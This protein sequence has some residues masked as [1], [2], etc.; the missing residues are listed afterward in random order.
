MSAEL[1]STGLTEK[2][3]IEVTA[4]QKLQILFPQKFPTAEARH[5]KNYLVEKGH[6]LALR[7]QTSKNIFKYEYANHDQIR[8]ERLRVELLSSFDLV[9]IDSHVLGEL[10]EVEKDQLHK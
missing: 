9:F 8:M 7:Y 6:S 2:L 3:P 1:S 5:L 10:S 4:E